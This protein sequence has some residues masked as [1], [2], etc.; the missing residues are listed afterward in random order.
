MTYTPVVDARVWA[1]PKLYGRS[2][3]ITC[4]LG[5]KANS[6]STLHR[7]VEDV[8]FAVMNRLANA[9]LRTKIVPIDFAAHSTLRYIRATM[10]AAASLAVP[11]SVGTA[12]G[13]V[14]M[15]ASASVAIPGAAPHWLA[16][17]L[18]ASVVAAGLGGILLARQWS[19]HGGALLREPV[20]RFLTCLCPALLAGA[21]LTIIEVADGNLLR[22]PGIW[23][24]L[25]G[26]A[27]VA[28]SAAATRILALLG[29]LFVLL[30]AVTLLLPADFHNALLGVGFGG[31]HLIFGAFVMKRGGNACQVR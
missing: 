15:L 2:I 21:V 1:A 16:I 28:A 6:Q 30:G 3:G 13:A 9:T 27:L 12:M 26:C 19:A 29:G 11:G 31:L 10:E 24:L 18:C 14:G 8:S 20:R 17:W 7:R 5:I 23:M 22:V 25:Y 4:R